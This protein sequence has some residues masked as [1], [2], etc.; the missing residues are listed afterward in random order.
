MERFSGL[1]TPTSSDES[2]LRDSFL[3]GI[4]LPLWTFVGSREESEKK[5]E[6]NTSS[7]RKKISINEKK[8]VRKNFG[9]C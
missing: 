9:S 5:R 2:T 8:I 7:S 4:G 1:F 3:L 6:L